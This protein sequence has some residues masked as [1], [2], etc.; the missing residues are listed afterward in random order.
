MYEEFLWNNCFAFGK[1]N[2]DKNN[3][4]QHHLNPKLSN[5]QTFKPSNPQTLKPFSPPQTLS[6]SACLLYNCG[7]IL[8]IL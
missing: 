4:V 1:C 5:P 3:A 8:T 6:Y 7:N 2:N